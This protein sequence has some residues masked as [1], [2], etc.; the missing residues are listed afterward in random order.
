MLDQIPGKEL[1]RRIAMGLGVGT[2]V[3]AILW[4]IGQRFR[5]KEKEAIEQMHA[6]VQSEGAPSD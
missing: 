1:A 5:K 6:E 4:P 3:G 2:V